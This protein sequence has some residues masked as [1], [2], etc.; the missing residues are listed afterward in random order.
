MQ[1]VIFLFILSSVHVLQ[2]LDLPGVKMEDIEIT[3]DAN[4]ILV[5][6]GHREKNRDGKPLRRSFQRSIQLPE[7][8]DTNKTTAALNDG[9]LTITFEKRDANL[10][11]PQK[12]QL[13]R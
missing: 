5:I 8:A 4:N 9:V 2:H 7:N 13:Q 11:A 10:Y 3:V 12:I 6:K 1:V